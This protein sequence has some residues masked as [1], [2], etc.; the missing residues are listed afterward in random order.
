MDVEDLVDQRRQAAGLR[1]HDVGVVLDLLGRA[2]ALEAERLGR[3][4][5][6]RERRPQLV[7][8]VQ[9]EVRLQ[10]RQPDR[11]AVTLTAHTTAISSRPTTAPSSQRPDGEPSGSGASGLT[12]SRQRATAGSG[13]R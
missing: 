4:R 11:F 12:T 6:H 9:H 10:L 8:D 5:Q 13:A 1:L 2:H 7:R 3:A